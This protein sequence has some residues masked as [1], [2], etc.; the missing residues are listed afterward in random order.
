MRKSKGLLTEDN[1][2]KFCYLQ[3]TYL[4]PVVFEDWRSKIKVLAGSASAE[5][6]LSSQNA[7]CGC[8]FTW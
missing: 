8:C 5:K 6:A 2:V 4:L 3:V 7:P 1:H